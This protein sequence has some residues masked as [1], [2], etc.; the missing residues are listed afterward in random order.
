MPWVN[1]EL[2]RQFAEIAGLLKLSGADRFRVRAYERA[3]DA[4]NT[5]RVDLGELDEAQLAALDGIGGSTARK[6]IQFRRDGEIAML[7]ELRQEVPAGLVELVRVPGLG[8]KT[9]R[10]LHDQL[11]ITSLDGLRAALASGRLRE[12]PG[13]GVKTEENLAA[14]LTRLDATLTQRTPLADRSS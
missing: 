2:G 3:R 10:Q 8:P 4:V 7:T 1:E 11:G 6:I 14:G 12:L 9:A 13:L 5:A